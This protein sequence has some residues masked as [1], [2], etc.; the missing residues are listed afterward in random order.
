M[1]EPKH[2][3]L[4]LPQLGAAPSGAIKANTIVIHRQPQLGSERL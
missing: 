1:G 2:Q 3:C 4:P